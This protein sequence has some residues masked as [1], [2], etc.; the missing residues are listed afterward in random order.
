MAE[1]SSSRPK[2]VVV[3]D[4]DNPLV[5]VEGEFFW[6]EDHEQI[7]ADACDEAFRR[8][9]RTGWGEGVRNTPGPRRVGY[10][11][12]PSLM[13][14]LYRWAG[15][16]ILVTGMIVLLIAALTTLANH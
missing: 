14:R 12:R 3:V 4:A 16:L 10:R 11:Y 5:E 1:Q 9:Y 2:R 15:A 6:R 8:G 7:V 13:T